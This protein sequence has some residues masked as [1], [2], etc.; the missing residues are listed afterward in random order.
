MVVTLVVKAIVIVVV[1]VVVEVVVVIVV[2]IVIEIE[3]M[4]VMV[5]VIVTR[6]ID[7]EWLRFCTWSVWSARQESSRRGVHADPQSQAG[8]GLRVHSAAPRVA[9]SPW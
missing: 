7:K 1:T 5:I 9:G 3:M 6:N 2:V 4:I 8:V